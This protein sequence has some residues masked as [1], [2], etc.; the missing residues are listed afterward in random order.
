MTDT[1]KPDP[2]D[3]QPERIGGRYDTIYQVPKRCPQCHKEWVGNYIAPALPDGQPLVHLCDDCITKA[4]AAIAAP[5]PENLD[6]FPLLKR[7]KRTGDWYD[8]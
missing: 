8:D 4:E 2:K 1:W 5:P 7:P 3:R 6:D